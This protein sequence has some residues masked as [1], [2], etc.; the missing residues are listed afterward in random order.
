MRRKQLNVSPQRPS[1][2]RALMSQAVSVS[3]RIDNL[4]TGL[5]KQLHM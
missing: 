4:E 1:L 5:R 3:N 2:L